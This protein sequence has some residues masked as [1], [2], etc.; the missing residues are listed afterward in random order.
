MVFAFRPTSRVVGAA[1]AEA[2]VPWLVRVCIALITGPGGWF[3]M[4]ARAADTPSI[5]VSAADVREVSD[6]ASATGDEI[7]FAAGD[8]WAAFDVEIPVAGRYR[9]TVTAK[10]TSDQPATLHIEDFIDNPDGRHYDITAAMPVTATFQ[11]SSKDGSPLDKG[12][13]RMKLHAHGSGL[14]VRAIEFSLLREHEP[15]LKLLE[16][17]TEGGE[18]RLVWA[19]EFDDEGQPD[20]TVWAHDLGNWGWGNN[21]PQYYTEGRLE[22]ARVEGGRLIIEARKDRPDGGWSSARLTTRGRVSFLYGRFEI[23][24]KATTGRGNWAAIWMLGDSY[25]DERSWPYCGEIDILE[26]VGREID[27]ASGDGLTHFCCHTRAHYFKDNSHI[28][29][30]K[31]VTGL[32]NRFHDYVLEWTPEAVTIFFDGE[33]VY[34]YDKQGG[35]WEYPFRQP[36]NLILNMAMGGGLGGEID[37]SL[38]SERMEVEYIRLYERG[39]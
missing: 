33:H 17:S 22:N 35:E 13:H 32:G 15:T 27:D 19:E 39:E 8:R 38:T 6:G 18:W 29:T 14:A 30:T 20:P 10:S 21:E 1:F 9:V 5:T 23:R 12:R 36:Q 37:P 25:R 34:T 7:A 24:A 3:V 2:V 28:S 16:Q 31:Q 4:S 11:D 26:N